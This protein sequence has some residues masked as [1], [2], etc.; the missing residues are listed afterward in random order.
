M[1]QLAALDD[2]EILAV[3]GRNLVNAEDAEDRT[4]DW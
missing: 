2:E 1:R 3:M 4:N